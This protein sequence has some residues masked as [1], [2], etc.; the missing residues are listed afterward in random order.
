MSLDPEKQRLLAAFYSDPESQAALFNYISDYNAKNIK[1]KNA[2]P[3]AH[4]TIATTPNPTINAATTTNILTAPNQFKTI[5]PASTSSAVPAQ[6]SPRQKRLRELSPGEN[7]TAITNGLSN[8]IAS[9]STMTRSDEGAPNATVAVGAEGSSKRAKSL[10][11]SHSIPTGER[12]RKN[13]IRLVL[14]CKPEEAEIDEIKIAKNGD[15]IIFAKDEHSYNK[16]LIPSGWRHSPEAS[17]VP[18]LNISSE[19]GKYVYVKNFDKTERVEDI[20]EALTREGIANSNIE[21][22]KLGTA[23]EPSYTVKVLVHKESDR[24]KLA[25]DGLIVNFMRHK[26]ETHVNSKIIQCYNCNKYGHLSKDCTDIVACLICAGPHTHR[27]CSV[28]KAQAHCTNCGGNHAASDRS[29]PTRIENIRKERKQATRPAPR[30]QSRE[31]ASGSRP[32]IVGTSAPQPSQNPWLKSNSSANHLF[33]AKATLSTTSNNVASRPEEIV[34]QVT[35]II[36]DALGETLNL[37]QDYFKDAVLRSVSRS[38]SKMFDIAA[39][40]RKLLSQPAQNN[41]TSN[42]YNSPKPS[43]GTQ[44]AGGSQTPSTTKG[45]LRVNRTRGTPA[46]PWAT[47]IATTP[48][49]PST[50]V[51]QP[52]YSTLQF[53]ALPSVRGAA[54]QGVF[55]ARSKNLNTSLTTGVRQLPAAPTAAASASATTSSTILSTTI[56][57]KNPTESNL[58]PAPPH[59]TTTRSTATAQMI[60]ATGPDAVPSS[61][62]MNLLS[63]QEAASWADQTSLTREESLS[64]TTGYSETRNEGTASPSILTTLTPVNPIGLQPHTAPQGNPSSTNVGVATRGRK[65]KHQNNTAPKQDPPNGS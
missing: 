28:D 39:V 6:D 26:C 4:A 2:V 12:D 61:P 50:P 44:S 32:H 14:E 10:I 3:S 20:V 49:T 52:T 21:R 7:L 17:F 65:A 40:A 16:L 64:W 35:K 42:P 57:T 9:A 36:M 55:S 45:P 63:I 18:R 27:E 46:T 58:P 34:V 30:Q 19:V 33:P 48:T 11:L 54:N 8:Q 24:V 60:G 1:S 15:I 38:Q 51:G 25:K 56:S 59:T 22:V 29:C 31:A 13:V 53:S 47:P 62:S 5:G 43:T 23:G 41:I 37:D